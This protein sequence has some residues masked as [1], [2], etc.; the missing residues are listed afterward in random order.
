MRNLISAFAVLVA[1]WLPLAAQAGDSR[2]SIAL[3]RGLEDALRDAIAERTQW[4]PD[5]IEIS[6]LTVPAGLAAAGNFLKVELPNQARL[7]GH[8]P[9]QVLTVGERGR[10]RQWA[11][12]RVEV[13]V[14][15]VV[16]ARTIGRHQV[17]EAT[18]LGHARLPLSR[19]HG[20][21]LEADRLVGMRATQ[22]VAQGGALSSRMV[23][24]PPVIHRGDPVTLRVRRP[25][26]LVSTLGEAREDGA[27]DGLIEVMNLSSRRTVQARVVDAS[28]VEVPF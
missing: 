13:M 14:D 10:V 27:P 7:T 26:L 17:I 15:T 19:I 8:L 6:G 4:Q 23:E 20:G 5:Q 25:G 24:Q 2:D 28:T 18:D 12:A 16:A 21:V 1:L 3:E 11:S 9:F 22:R